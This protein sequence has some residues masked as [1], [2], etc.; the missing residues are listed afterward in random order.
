MKARSI[1][2]VITAGILLMIA[3]SIYADRQPSKIIPPT[4]LEERVAYLETR[5]AVLERRLIIHV[6]DADFECHICDLPPGEI[7]E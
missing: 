1:L 5:V 7:G 2:V 4:T 6:T 3:T